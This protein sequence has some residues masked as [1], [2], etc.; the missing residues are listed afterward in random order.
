MYTL[1][2]MEMS[3]IM[4]KLKETE[5]KPQ[6]KISASLSIQKLTLIIKFKISTKFSNPLEF[7]QVCLNTVLM[8]ETIINLSRKSTPRAMTIMVTKSK[9]EKS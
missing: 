5:L 8:K 6:Y 7:L 4:V 9:Q 3:I 2:Q 1:D